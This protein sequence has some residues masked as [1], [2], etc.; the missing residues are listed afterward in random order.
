[1]GDENVNFNDENCL[2][3]NEDSFQRLIQVSF[4]KIV[5]S[6]HERGGAKLR[7][8]LLVLHLLQRARNEQRRSLSPTELDDLRPP[9]PQVPKEVPTEEIKEPSLD[10]QERVPEVKDEQVEEETVE[11]PET[12]AIV[13]T[14]LPQPPT[15]ISRLSS[16]S[17]PENQEDSTQGELPENQE[18][19][20]KERHSS[21]SSSGYDSG[22]SSSSSDE[23]D[24]DSA[25]SRERRKRKRL[26]STGDRA[27][28]G[29]GR[30]K[31][32][33]AGEGVSGL[34]S[35]FKAG[36]AFQQLTCQS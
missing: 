32:C 17:D 25:V 36:L 33:T 5:S 6:K 35:V 21:S 19:F 28:S 16:E 30:K 1:M 11:N 9:T 20:F 24:P 29:D 18:L 22:S 7:K 13:F 14:P 34:I 15:F 3:F 10:S 12:S 26:P 2:V 8:N 23:D 4:A 31:T 27:P